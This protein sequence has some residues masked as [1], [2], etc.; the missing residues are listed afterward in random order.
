[1]IANDAFA[2]VAAT[3]MIAMAI[4]DLHLELVAAA[5]AWLAGWWLLRED[6]V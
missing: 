4:N 6:S 1:M 3:S 5:A 2:S